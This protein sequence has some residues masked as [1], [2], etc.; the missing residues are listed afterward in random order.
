MDTDWKALAEIWGRTAAHRRRIDS[1][2][3]CLDESAA[4]GTVGVSVSWGKDSTALLALAIEHLGEAVRAFHLASPYRLPGWEVPESYFR[5]ILGTR[6]L[7]LD[8]P[9]SL[10]ELIQHFQ[11]HGL[12]HEIDGHHGRAAT[13]KKTL[14]LEACQAL[15]VSV[16]ALGIRADESSRRRQAAGS[17]AKPRRLA[18]GL[19]AAWPLVGLAA[20]DI[21]AI[22]L[23]YGCPYH[24]MYDLETH[25][26]TR[27]TLR[28]GG[29][30]TT[31]DPGRLPWLRRHYPHQY[32][33]LVDAFPR[34]REYGG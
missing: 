8:Y 14:G 13:A 11:A 26:L 9:V 4:L 18:D 33:Q 1:A 2:R 25:G 15:G 24:P 23:R 19:F 29:W 20:I 22:L 27:F 31:N 12:P 3:H 30:L 10:E 16:R 5:P 32:E 7:V 6:Y 28:N 21:W 17:F 34:L